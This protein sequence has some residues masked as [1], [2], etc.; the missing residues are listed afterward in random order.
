MG[1]LDHSTTFV[2]IYKNRRQLRVLIISLKQ[3]ILD[4]NPIKKKGNH[5]PV[6]IVKSEIHYERY[7]WPF[8]ADCGFF[9]K[10][11][12]WTQLF[13]MRVDTF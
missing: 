11:Q 2:C 6:H 4:D 7:D 10:F 12:V 1:A 8:V 5:R 3:V 9:L 13:V